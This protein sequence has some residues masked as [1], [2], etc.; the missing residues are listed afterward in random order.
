MTFEIQ[1]KGDLAEIK[2]TTQWR[3][4]AN[5]VGFAFPVAGYSLQEN[6]APTQW[7]K[8]RLG[9]AMT[10][11]NA[12][13]NKF[14]KAI[15]SYETYEPELAWY[16]RKRDNQSFLALDMKK[17]NKKSDFA[18]TNKKGFK[19]NDRSGIASISAVDDFD[20]GVVSNDVEMTNKSQNINELAAY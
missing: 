10:A 11:S 14:D 12:I 6:W 15:V 3:S 18:F 5:A 16:N 2:I 4:G 1:E 8:N 17:L 20:Y 7:E 9:I 19:R 13:A